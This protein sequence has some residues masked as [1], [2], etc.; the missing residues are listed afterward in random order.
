MT[1]PNP[2]ADAIEALES[3]TDQFRESLQEL[4]TVVST[5]KTA[6]PNLFNTFQRGYQDWEVSWDSEAV[7]WFSR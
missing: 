6:F 7:K 4:D 5:L 3:T 1:Y 2:A